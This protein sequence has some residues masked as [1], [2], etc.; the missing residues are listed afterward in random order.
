MNKTQLIEAVAKAANVSKKDSK[1]AVEATLEA[2]KKSLVAG[3]KVQL[4]GFGT[5]ET[6]KRPARTGKNPRTGE[7]VKIAAA[8]VPAFKAGKALKEAVN[9]KKK[10]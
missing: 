1:A 2:I 10:K 5:F 4:I 9:K 7:S 6:R 8:K 3:D